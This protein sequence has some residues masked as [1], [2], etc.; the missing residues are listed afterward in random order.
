MI[1]CGQNPNEKKLI[2][3]WYGIENNGYTSIE[4]Y[5]DSLIFIEHEREVSQWHAT[6]SK[7]EFSIPT[8]ISDS[9]GSL[10][11]VN[12]KVKV[13]YSLSE[14]Q[15]TLYG[16]FENRF[17]ENKFNLLRANNYIEFLNKK[18]DITFSL[19]QDDLVEPIITDA[20]YG[21]KVFVGHSGNK[22]IGKTEFSKDLNNLDPDINKFMANISPSEKFMIETHEELLDYRFHFRVFADKEIPDSTILNILPRM[23]K[24]SIP[25]RIFRIYKSDE[26]WE[27]GKMRGKNINTIANN[28]YPSAGLNR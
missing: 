21:L 2:G 14:D 23:I 11:Y 5:T 19:P 28:G 16:I 17:G 20:I 24:D 25:V 9:T 13:N 12:D 3:K 26:Q 27:I 22:I 6:N 7:I 4:F 1:S 10:S 15:D 8:L 18:Y